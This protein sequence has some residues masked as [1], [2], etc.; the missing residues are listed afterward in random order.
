MSKTPL[1]LADIH[2]GQTCLGIKSQ[3]KWACCVSGRP[4]TVT[5]SGENYIRV[6]SPGRTKAEETAATKTLSL[7]HQTITAQWNDV[8]PDGKV[9]TLWWEAPTQGLSCWSSSFRSHLAPYLVYEIALC[10]LSNQSTTHQ[11]HSDISFSSACPL[12]LDAELKSTEKTHICSGEKYLVLWLQRNI[13]SVENVENKEKQ[14]EK[15]KQL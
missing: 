12:V 2:V 15:K 1:G 11:I 4:R 6:R 14:K 9:T 13:N 3:T 7:A 10:P 5:V 8:P